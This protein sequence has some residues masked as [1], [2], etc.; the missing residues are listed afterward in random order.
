MDSNEK[1]RQRELDARRQNERKDLEVERTIG[2][3]PLEGLSGGHTTWTGE[4]DDAARDAHANDEAE[5][6]RRSEEQLER[7]PETG[8]K[9]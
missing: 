2:E 5:S 6:R 3:R 7:I 8:P 4:Q 1:Q 9:K